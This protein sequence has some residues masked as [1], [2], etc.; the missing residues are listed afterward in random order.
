MTTAADDL[1]SRPREGSEP[2]ARRTL[3]PLTG[4]AQKR[5]LFALAL[6]LPGCAPKAADTGAKPDAAPVAV[7]VEPVKAVTLPRTVSVV[8]T[9]DPYREVTLAPK[10][11][12]RVLRVRRDI[13]DAVYPG[14][15]LLELDD[16]A[17][18]DRS[19]SPAAKIYS[20]CHPFCLSQSHESFSAELSPKRLHC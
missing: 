3:R 4:P 7:T 17:A 11:D 15:A 19:P 20:H 13:G 18:Y 5:I 12:G 6:L 16:R 9:L 14:E 2:A 1:L 10:V 8:G